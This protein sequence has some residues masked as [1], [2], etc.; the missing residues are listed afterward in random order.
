[1]TSLWKTRKSSA[2]THSTAINQISRALTKK[3]TKNVSARVGFKVDTT[4]RVKVASE[5]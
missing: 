2:T 4:E 1:M 5:L 3:S